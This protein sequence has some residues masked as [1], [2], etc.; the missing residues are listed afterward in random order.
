MDRLFVTG[1][2]PL[3]GTV[4][5]AGAKNSALKLMAA[6]LLADGRTTLRNVPKIQDCITMVEVLEHLGVACMWDDG[7]LVLETA[8]VRPAETPYELVSRMRASILVLG[9]LLATFGTAKVAMPGGCNIGSRAIDLH[10]RGLEKMGAR[11][12]SE[13]GF[14]I[15]ETNGLRGAIVN[16]D[17]PS[18]GATENVL[19]AAVAA[20]GTTVIENAAREPELVDLADLLTEMGARIDGVGTPTIEIEGVEGFG[21]TDHT[22]IPD[23]VEAGTF[24]IAA[25]ATGGRVVLD[26]ARSDHLDLVLSK[27]ADAGADVLATEEGVAVSMGSRARCVDLVTLPYPGFPTDLQPQM[28]ALLA[29]ADG[30]SIVTENVFESRFMFVDELNRMGADIRTE[31]HHAVLRGVE[32]LSSAPVRALDIRAGA[33]MVVAAL[34]ADG[35]T[36]I[37]DMYHVDRGYQDFEAKLTSLG[38]VLRR[39]RELSPALS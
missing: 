36:E 34:S 33:A 6:A 37:E 14:L 9:P 39:E 29:A 2:S 15:G 22:V 7:A 20:K 8:G 18:V 13:H 26:G 27:L 31:G 4:E 1:G 16:L 19:M 28:M 10:I 5:I 38:A 25:C 35:V 30:T 21:P 3:D 23:R 12:H 24:A 17:F 32:R 11:F